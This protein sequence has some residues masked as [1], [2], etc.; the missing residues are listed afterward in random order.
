[1]FARQLS[2]SFGNK[3]KHDDSSL[4]LAQK[5]NQEE[6]EIGIVSLDFRERR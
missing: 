1:M 4:G 3:R 5:G 2:N 6:W